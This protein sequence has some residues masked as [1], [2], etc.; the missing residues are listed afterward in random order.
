[1]KYISSI[2]SVIASLNFSVEVRG[3]ENLDSIPNLTISG[4]AKSEKKTH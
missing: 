3:D 1:M 2:A 4:A